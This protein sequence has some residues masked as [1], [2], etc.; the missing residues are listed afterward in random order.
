MKKIFKHL[1]AFLSVVFVMSFVAAC[2]PVTQEPVDD[3]TT[4]ADVVISP[5]VTKVN[6][7]TKVTLTSAGADIYYEIVPAGSNSTLTAE[8]YTDARFTKYKKSF[9]AENGTVYAIA[10]K[11][12]KT[13]AIT[14]RKYTIL[15]GQSNVPAD[16]LKVE[17][18]DNTVWNGTRDTEI[19][20]EAPADGI[21]IS[22]LQLITAGPGAD[23]STE[24]TVSWHSPVPVNYVEYTTADDTSF[25]RSGKIWIKAELTKA[26]D[27]EGRNDSG[28]TVH[29]GWGRLSGSTIKLDHTR[30]YV[31]KAKLEGLK[32]NTDYIYRVG[33]NGASPLS[34]GPFKFKTAGTQGGQF[35]FFWAADL[36][37]PSGDSK[38]V[39]R[40]SE[41]IGFANANLKNQS[42][43]EVS[44]V[45]FTGDLVEEGA[46]Y[47]SWL[48]WDAIPELR[49]YMWASCV[50]NHDYY[51]DESYRVGS[52]KAR[53]SPRW[54][55]E[56]TAF[57][58]TN[59]YTK[60]D[61]SVEELPPSNYWYLYNRVLFIGIDSMLEESCDPEYTSENSAQMRWFKAVLKENEEKYDYIVAFQHFAYI[62]ND[63]VM[64]GHYDDWKTVYDEAGVDFALSSDSHEYDRTFELY[65]DRAIETGKNGTVYVTSPMTEGSALDPMTNKA[66]GKYNSKSEFYAGGVKGGMYFVVNSNSMTMYT[67]GKNGTV[68]D[69]KTVGRKKRAWN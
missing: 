36:H 38:Y 15:S 27:F 26:E 58:D 64:Y 10:V 61:S 52:Q 4:P 2:G 8:N 23:C 13:S 53:V 17:A 49:E 63:K 56:C 55:Y 39:K 25:A 7:G 5:K 62:V 48:Y 9:T 32:P 28:S 31:C 20:Y 42:L 67:I 65:K 37:T 14:N 12:S 22:K 54:Q 43:P 46:Y 29:Y 21:T 57:P 47:S 3:G 60:S 33:T 41:L 30:F 6:T 24:M 11:G 59:K 18:V 69:E 44:Y 68:F 1:F 40:I 16:T 45:L 34:A 50:G 51:F 35:T 66:P 19:A